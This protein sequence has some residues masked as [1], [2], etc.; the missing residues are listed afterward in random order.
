LSQLSEWIAPEI[1]DG[2]EEEVI[3]LQ[4]SGRRE[5]ERQGGER[6]GYVISNLY[7]T[8]VNR[9]VSAIIDTKKKDRDRCGRLTSCH[10][11]TRK[12]R[13]RKGKRATAM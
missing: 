2:P 10:R 4:G 3:S 6:A 13:W 11:C 5:S 7:A 12:P 8:V 9:Q 1:S